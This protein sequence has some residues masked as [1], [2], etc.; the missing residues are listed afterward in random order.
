MSS[1]P[2][3]GRCVAL[4]LLYCVA[5][6]LTV[7][8]C[9][10]DYNERVS[11]LR[12]VGLRGIEVHALLATQNTVV[13]KEACRNANRALNVD[14]PYLGDTVSK[15]DQEAWARLAEDTFVKACVLGQY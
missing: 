8:S 2:R 10:A 1:K 6:T 3:A 15:E 13:T 12:S 5:A 7:T 11:Y 14:N 4:T 9:G